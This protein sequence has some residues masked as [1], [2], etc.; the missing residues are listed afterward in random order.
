MGYRVWVIEVLL[1][2]RKREMRRKVE[3]EMEIERERMD[4]RLIFIVRKNS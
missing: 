2:Q 4:S 1:V 3:M